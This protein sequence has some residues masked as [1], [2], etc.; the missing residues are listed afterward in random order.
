MKLPIETIVVDDDLISDPITDKELLKTTNID[1]KVAIIQE[2]N[3]KVISIRD[4]FGEIYN[5]LI[6][7]DKIKAISEHAEEVL[8][9]TS[10]ESYTDALSIVGYKESHD[11]CEK[12][13]AVEQQE[14]DN[15]VHDFI[16][17]DI[18]AV[19][20]LLERL[21]ESDLSK[22]IQLV[23]NTAELSTMYIETMSTSKET[24]LP[25]K[26]E[27]STEFKDVMAMSI[28]GLDVNTLSSNKLTNKDELSDNIKTIMEIID[29]SSYFR[30]MFFKAIE[31]KDLTLM[32]DVADLADY[33]ER[34]ICMYDVLRFLNSS[35]LTAFTESLSREITVLLSDLEDVLLYADIDKLSIVM[36]DI[37]NLAI[38]RYNIPR[39]SLAV[40][41]TMSQLKLLVI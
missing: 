11:I 38:F 28:V 21:I 1:T 7:K 23:K 37:Q 12:K 29:S 24:I 27:D 19:K 3:A 8:Q 41:N 15:L 10:L 31:K 6:N 5:G 18:A 22:F 34:D 14:L 13:L 20:T 32:H 40:K 35:S 26:S 17:N 36:S 16:S 2:K 9:R 30:V 25:I 39:I 4:L 33:I